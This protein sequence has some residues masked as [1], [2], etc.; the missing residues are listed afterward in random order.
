MLESFYLLFSHSS[1]QGERSQAKGRLNIY[2][3][4][5]TF[6]LHKGEINKRRKKEIP[7]HIFFPHHNISIFFSEIPANN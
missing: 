1:N 7:H 4:L 5:Q 2:G 6:L 3:H